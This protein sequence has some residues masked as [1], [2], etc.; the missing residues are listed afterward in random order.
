MC[1]TIVLC[2][3]SQFRFYDSKTPN[4]LF[5]VICGDLSKTQLVGGLVGRGLPTREQFGKMQKLRHCL[6]VLR[7][8]PV[9]GFVFI[10][11]QLE[12][13]IRVATVRH[14]APSLMHS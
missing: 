5:N 6:P 8:Y 9:V 10:V 11:F 2:L 3:V 13:C 7:Q 12:I 14:P 1:C 4:H